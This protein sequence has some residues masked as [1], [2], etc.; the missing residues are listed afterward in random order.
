MN[1]EILK[2][3]VPNVISNLSIPLL[4]TVDTILMGQL[5]ALHLAAVGIAGMIFNLFY[6]NFGFLRMGTTGMTAQAYGASDQKD[7]N[8]VLHR[9]L[10]LAFSIALIL[11]IL[12]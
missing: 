9:S 10:F 4:S 1:K 8:L 7:F 5:S 6:W 3:A 11:M 12:P 2:L